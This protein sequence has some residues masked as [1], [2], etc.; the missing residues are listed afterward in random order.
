V[1][2]WNDNDKYLKQFG[3][4]FIVRSVALTLIGLTAEYTEQKEE[5]RLFLFVARTLAVFGS[6]RW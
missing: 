5:G 6:V 1:H 4:P 2:G 3:Q